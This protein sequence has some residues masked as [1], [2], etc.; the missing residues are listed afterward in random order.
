MDLTPDDVADI[1][2]VID[3]AQV[4]ELRLETARFKLTLRREG[5]GWVQ[6][7]ETLGEP[8]VIELAAA[9]E[10]PPAAAAPSTDGLHDVLAPLPGTFYRAGEPGAPPFVEVGD[11]VEE[12]TVVGLLETMKLFNSVHAGVRGTVAE[13]CVSNAAAAEQ[14]A[15]LARVRPAGTGSSTA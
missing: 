11:A 7:T 3:S 1:L 9:P 13:I 8:E 4:N 12:D 5:D 10:A 6:E 15:V 14:G 2:R